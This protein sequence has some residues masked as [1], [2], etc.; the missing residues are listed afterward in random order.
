[1]IIALCY[2]TLFTLSAVLLHAV[3]YRHWQ[4]MRRGKK[5]NE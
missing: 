5:A 3:G 4:E 2:I 1:M